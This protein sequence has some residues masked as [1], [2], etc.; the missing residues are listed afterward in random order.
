MAATD[1][2]P[3]YSYYKGTDGSWYILYHTTNGK[4]WK[5]NAVEPGGVQFNQLSSPPADAPASPTAAA[6]SNTGPTTS[7][8]QLLTPATLP[9]GTGAG[10]SLRYPTDI[11][12]VDKS[13]YVIF[14]F[15]KYKPPFS[16]AAQKR[17]LGS[18]A[19]TAY[20][21][22]TNNLEPADLPQILLYMPEGV[23][24]SY[25]A[26]WDGKA[27]GN[28]AA[29][30]LRTAGAAANDDYIQAIKN[31]GTTAEQA[32]KNAT[33]TLGAK[34]IQALTKTLT[35]DSVGVQD[36]FSSIGGAILNPNVELIF[37]GHDLRTLQLTFKMVPYNKPE[38]EAIDRI[39]KTF[40]EAMLPRLN[41]NNSGKFWGALAGNQAN[42]SAVGANQK[43]GSGFIGVPDLV[44]INFMQ[45]GKENRNV[46]KYKVCSIT[47]FD[48]NYSPDGV[49][50]VGPDGYPVATEIRVNFMETKLVYSEDIEFGY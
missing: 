37:G 39:V 16:A 36:I 4:Q 20:N 46:A 21:A 31:I 2:I 5:E 29:G 32:V 18:N 11:S 14:S 22:Q 7:S 30:I 9:I 1:G 27:F 13:H 6:G 8:L 15:K 47:D 44:Q 40:K 41:H 3:V 19:L 43:Y 28:I 48:V 42:Q 50:A 45:G 35:G 34:G 38:A 26:N 23:A 33:S 24:A 10:S 25:K 12:T 17:G 49:Y